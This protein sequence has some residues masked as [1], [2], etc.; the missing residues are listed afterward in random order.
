VLE[1]ADTLQGQH[2]QSHHTQHQQGVQGQQQQGVQEPIKFTINM[3]PENTPIHSHG[4]AKRD[5]EIYH[6]GVGT[7]FYSKYPEVWIFSLFFHFCILTTA[8][9]SQY[10]VE[11]GVYRCVL[12]MSVL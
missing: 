6:L 1:T 8:F 4:L 9:G 2:Q 10:G 7:F 3:L 11:E 5:G 12:R